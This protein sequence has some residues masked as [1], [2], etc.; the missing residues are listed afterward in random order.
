MEICFVRH[1]ETDW[2]VEG[3]LQGHTPTSLNE[4]GICQS[5]QCAE[6]LAGEAWDLIVSSP[7]QRSK[8]SA[9]ILSSYLA[10]PWIVSNG[11]SEIDYGSWNGEKRQNL[12]GNSSFSKWYSVEIRKIEKR[13]WGDLDN[14]SNTFK[15]KRVIVVTHGL[16][17]QRIEKRFSKNSLTNQG[18]I[19]NGSFINIKL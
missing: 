14:L 5:R 18:I 15:N 1:G 10:V 13:I 3:R 9:D 12:M 6:R 19:S 7:L 17:I 8:E 4:T 2:N 11:F 16:V